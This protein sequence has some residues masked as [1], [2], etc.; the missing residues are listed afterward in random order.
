MADENV[1][2]QDDEQIV[3][4]IL[5]KRDEPAPELDTDNMAHRFPAMKAK[6]EAAES[7][8]ATTKAQ[9]LAL[10]QQYK[11]LN[12]VQQQAKTD[13]AIEAGSIK[14]VVEGFKATISTQADTIKALEM[15]AIRINMSISQELDPDLFS[16]VTGDD[17]AEIMASI[18]KWKSKFDTMVSKN[19]Q[20]A[21]T[22]T[23]T[24]PVN[25][26]QSPDWVSSAKKRGI[27]TSI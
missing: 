5:K 16:V 24:A 17:E 19:A 18:L 6:R 23:A 25:N 21:P 8:L 2:T 15:Q 11:E 7:A 20:V 10:E 26:G 1:P 22:A 14:D 9:Y 12:E 4:D 13:K 27:P 3:A